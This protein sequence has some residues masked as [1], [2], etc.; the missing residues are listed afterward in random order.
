MEMDGAHRLRKMKRSVDQMHP[1]DQVSSA[2]LTPRVQDVKVA[3]G[4]LEKVAMTWA[5]RQQAQS[6]VTRFVTLWTLEMSMFAISIHAHGLHLMEIVAL[7]LSVAATITIVDL[8][9]Q[10]GISQETCAN[11]AVPAHKS[12]R[13]N[14]TLLLLRMIP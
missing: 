3:H 13:T 6:N 5:F 2:I 1:V 10:V 9:L 14:A 4:Q 8:T 7:T 12:L 11:N